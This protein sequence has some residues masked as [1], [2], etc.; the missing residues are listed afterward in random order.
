MA[1]ILHAQSLCVWHT[2]AIYHHVFM[3]SIKGDFIWRNK[4]K[5]LI[6]TVRK[7]YLN[8]SENLI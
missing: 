8:L 7:S 6:F 3:T 1:I 2:D 4:S 5:I